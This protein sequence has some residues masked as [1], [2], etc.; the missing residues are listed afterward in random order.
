M[1][2]ITDIEAARRIP[3]VPVELLDRLGNPDLRALLE[4]II[5]ALQVLHGTV[6]N[7]L[8]T[9]VTRRDLLEAGLIEIYDTD[10]SVIGYT[11]SPA[12]SEP[13][14]FGSA[15]GDVSITTETIPT[16]TPSTP[17]GLATSGTYQHVFLKW[18]AP[19]YLGH[20]YTEIWR[21]SSNSLAAATKITDIP[22]GGRAYA[23][24]LGSSGVTR[25]YWIRHV[26]TGST[27]GAYNAGESGGTSGTTTASPSTTQ[28]YMALDGADI[29]H[30]YAITAYLADAAITNAKIA[31]AT[32]SGG[33][34]AATTL[35]ADLYSELRNTITIHGEDSLDA[36]YP[37]VV[38]FQIPSEV[39][40]IVDVSV[41][42]RILP[43]RAYS[44]SGTTTSAG[45]ESL[46]SDA[47]TIP[48]IA[49]HS[50]NLQVS[51]DA[52]T[53]NQVAVLK[54][55]SSG[56]IGLDSTAGETWTSSTA[57]GHSH[58]LGLTSVGFGNTVYFDSGSGQLYT[59]GG[60]TISLPTSDGHEHTITVQ[61]GTTGVALYWDTSA[62]RFE[63]RSG[64]G[65][66]VA[67]SLAQVDHDH[68]VT[69]S[70]HTHAISFGIYEED[71][72]GSAS[73]DLDTSNNGTSFSSF[74]TGYTADQL[75]VDITSGF[76]GTGW[77]AVKFSSNVRARIVY[78]VTLKVDLTA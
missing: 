23:D 29:V 11:A 27:A 40:D 39:T 68:G 77:K 3:Q 51:L 32:I 4:P 47:A 1:A 55:V 69:T 25:Y 18:D 21:A 34:I 45:G 22:N 16:G 12:S 43:F 46:T 36:T 38:D 53:S 48:T 72:T 37:L 2:T 10:G 50:H 73:I 64:S 63:V 49:T 44:Q 66:N 30:L 9:A 42:F 65:G 61:D 35:T 26:N 17:S 7:S 20:S 58:S 75:E 62:N 74:A 52:G 70:N 57:E 28:G 54:F 67:S 78:N 6:G 19:T 76:T 8:D 13:Q 41:S 71:N 24:D 31:N 5:E 33:K 15:V 59:S 14:A 56:V 60:G